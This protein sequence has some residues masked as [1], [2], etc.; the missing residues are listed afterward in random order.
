MRLKIGPS[1]PEK[2]QMTGEE[3][4]SLLRVRGHLM[5]GLLSE[6]IKRTDY[7]SLSDAD[8]SK[9]LEAIMKEAGEQ[10]R[11]VLRQAVAVRII[12]ELNGMKPADATRRLQQI[13]KSDPVLY[14]QIFLTSAA[15]RSAQ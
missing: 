5:N 2:G 8:K 11:E 1:S 10:S 12:Q 15:G 6:T 7:Q 9:T 14:E 13:E 4:R 3:Y